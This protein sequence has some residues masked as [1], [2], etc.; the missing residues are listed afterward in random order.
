MVAEPVHSENTVKIQNF[1]NN[2]FVAPEQN[3][4]L[5]VYEPATA[6]IYASLAAS[7]TA[8]VD[9][10][11][12]AASKAA[13]AW[14]ALAPAA[15]AKYLYKLSAAIKD[16]FDEFAIAESKDN[17]KPI[18]NS[19]TIDIPR[20][21]DNL[22]F[23]AAAAE[24]FASE[25]HA[26]SSGV[27]NFTL[28]QPL[29]VV[30][31]ISPWNFPLH[32]LSW[33]IAPALAAGNTVVAKPSE[34]TPNTA[35]LLAECCQQVGFPPGVI[36]FVH[37]QGAEAGA[38]LVN[39]PLVKA[40]SFTGS[41]AT[42]RVIARQMAE[43]FKK[44]SLE[45]GGKNPSIVFADCDLD[46]AIE[47]ITR[48][49]FSNQG[50]VCLCGSR[51]LVEQS[52]YPQVRAALVANAKALVIGDPQDPATQQG[53]LVSSEHQQKVLDYIQLAQ[54]E[55]GTLLCGGKAVQLPGRCQNGWFVEPTLIE[56]LNQ[57]CRTNQEEIFGPVATIQPFTDEAEALKL[58]NQTDYGLACSI[59]SRD[60]DRCQRMAHK[61]EAGIIW[62]NSWMER[63]DLRTPF[64]GVKQ[65]GVGREGGFEAMRFFTETKNV[66]IKYQA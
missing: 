4:W 29:G 50:Q 21:I 22:R 34:V 11:C 9:A 25:S 19:R 57:D 46:K 36:N 63:R 58:A 47:G 6:E 43:Q 26:G 65:S 60:L 44:Y 45:M 31:C 62:V 41:T 52:I 51:I 5:D 53:A 17:G 24:H 49:A 15:R 61:I 32:L 59:W 14:A 30:V 10:A 28:R 42:G 3:Q 8:D 16:R 56:G 35:N 40:V 48:A 27:I 37:G 64:G 12:A 38:A 55:G 39:H 33:K 66:C 18:N 2:Q 54:T 1:I 20:S 7:T 13:P 23:Y